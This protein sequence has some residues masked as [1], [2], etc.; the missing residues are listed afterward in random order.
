[1]A[2]SGE[3]WEKVGESG[4]MLLKKS[5][6]KCGKVWKSGKKLL[7]VVGKWGNVGK[8]VKNGEKLEKVAKSG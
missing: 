3:N 6:K 1:M 5:V 8:V 4:G 2:K 7:K